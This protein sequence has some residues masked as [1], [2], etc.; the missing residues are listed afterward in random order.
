MKI[1]YLINTLVFFLCASCASSRTG[2]TK[3]LT[4]QQSEQAITC[5][6][7][8]LAQLAQ[9]IEIDASQLETIK[10]KEY[11]PPKGDEPRG[12]L[13][14]ETEITRKTES[15][16]KDSTQMTRQGTTSLTAHAADSLHSAAQEQVHQESDS[17]IFHPRLVLPLI[18]ILGLIISIY[19]FRLKR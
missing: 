1:N 13:K 3:R 19:I 11:Y 9:N 4:S 7:A 18:L 16:R 8:S 10:I 15:Q 6:H 5:N 2:S 17:R 12:A 14:S